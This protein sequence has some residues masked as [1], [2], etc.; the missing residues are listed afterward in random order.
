MD[1]RLRAA[2]DEITRTHSTKLLLPEVAARVGLS[3]R[4]LQ[5]LFVEETGM[6]YIAYRRRLRM[7]LAE[8]LLKNT[9]KEVRDVTSAVG[10]KA[11]AYFCREFKKAQ[12]STSTRFRERTGKT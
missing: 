1:P 4:R 2:I 12:G 3:V 10:Y 11:S 9:G 8:K 7:Q 6:T 5:Q